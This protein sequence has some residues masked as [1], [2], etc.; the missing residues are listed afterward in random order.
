MAV[1]NLVMTDIITIIKFSE[2]IYKNFGKN[3]WK[4]DSEAFP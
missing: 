3:G 2:N 4:P 1:E